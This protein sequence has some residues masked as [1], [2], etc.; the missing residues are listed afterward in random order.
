MRL[1]QRINR[2]KV[3]FTTVPMPEISIVNQVPGRKIQPKD[4]NTVEDCIT[5]ANNESFLGGRSQPSIGLRFIKENLPFIDILE[6][7]EWEEYERI[8]SDYDIVGISFY[9]TNFFSA[10]KMAGIARKKGVKEVWAGNYGA[11]TPTVSRFFDRIFTGMSERELAKALLGYDLEYIKHPVVTTPF[12]SILGAN[13]E[14]GY[15]FTIRGCK[16][17]CSFCCSHRF[18][19][20]IDKMNFGEI[21]RVLDCYKD[22]GIRYINIGDET[23]LQ[24]RP[25]S[26]KVLE[27]LRERGMKWFCSTRA[28]LLRNKV[29]ELKPFGLDSVYIGIESMNDKNLSD[30][31]KG[32]SIQ[33]ILSV[34]EE[35]KDNRIYSSGT[36]ILGLLNDTE[37]SILRDLEKLKTL[38]VN[39]LIFLIMTPYPELPIYKEF[40]EKGLITTRNWTKYDGMNLV[41]KHPNISKEVLHGLFDHAVCTVYSPYNYNKRRVLQRLDKIRA[42]NGDQ[43]SNPKELE[44]TCS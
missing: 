25:H 6:F 18:S 39:I 4:L 7:P 44:N 16:F 38:P 34:L 9:T 1:N 17:K 11:R 13:E 24:D 28:D 2:K 8:V 42:M 32:Q 20:V 14:A 5:L 12:S 22:K 3:L 21:I 30:Q 36:Y 35:L 15:L 27:L 29:K 41:F 23:F 26:K 31:H 10:V 19:P 40:D 37:E 33:N 43:E